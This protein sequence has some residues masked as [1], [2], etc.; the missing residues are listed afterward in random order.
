MENQTKITNESED[1]DVGIPITDSEIRRRLER[2]NQLIGSIRG[3][4]RPEI[5]SFGCNGSKNVEIHKGTEEVA[6]TINTSIPRNQSDGQ[7]INVAG[8]LNS[9]TWQKRHESIRR[10]YDTDGIAPTIPTGTGGGVMT[11]IVQPVLTPDR[12]EKRQNGRRFKEDGE[13]SFT[14]T[15]Q[16]IHG[17]M[18]DTKIR[19][20]TPIECLR[21]Q[22][23]PDDWFPEDLSNTQRYKQMG[24]AVTVNVIE[25]IITMMFNTQQMKGAIK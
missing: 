24:N 14:L 1:K 10:V 17:V 20:L 8:H 16:D 2:F 23:F 13:P 25:A 7:Y 3:I 18:E 21:L 19:R 9:E 12:P 6:N 5:L 22:G 15:G 4:R 11:K